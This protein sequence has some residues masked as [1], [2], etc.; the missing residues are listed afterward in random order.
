MGSSAVLTENLAGPEWLQRV[1]AT[2]PCPWFY[3]SP[4]PMG[5]ALSWGRSIGAETEGAA[6][7]AQLPAAG[8]GGDISL[9]QVKNSHTHQD[10]AF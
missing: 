4:F 6:S 1:P 8:S 9:H 10:W 7:R 2:T 5:C 3:L